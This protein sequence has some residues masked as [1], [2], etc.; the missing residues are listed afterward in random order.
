[1]PLN[2]VT[3]TG[4]GTDADGS[5]AAYSWTKIAGPGAGT[6]TSPTAAQTTVSAL[7]QGVYSFELKVTDN[8]AV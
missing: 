4:T 8:L 3:L 7:A 2:V 5:I 1:L 6:I